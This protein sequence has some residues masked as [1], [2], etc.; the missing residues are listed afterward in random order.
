MVSFCT[1]ELT[2]G[3]VASYSIDAVAMSVS[4]TKVTGTIPTEI[5][6]LAHLESLSFL[7]TSITGTIPSEIGLLTSLTRLDGVQTKLQGKLPSEIGHVRSLGM[8][9]CC[10]SHVDV[11]SDALT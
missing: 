3:V 6:V 7:I 9:C 10:A 8:F 5:G 11:L 4:T 2:D 1:V